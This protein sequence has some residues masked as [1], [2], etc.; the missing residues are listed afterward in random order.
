MWFP[1]EALENSIL[2]GFSLNYRRPPFLGPYL[3]CT[4]SMQHQ[5][6]CDTIAT[7]TSLSS[8]GLHQFQYEDDHSEAES[9]NVL[10]TSRKKLQS[11]EDILQTKCKAYDSDQKKV[12]TLSAPAANVT[13]PN[14]LSF[15][16]LQWLFEIVPRSGFSSCVSFFTHPY[17]LL[18]YL[19]TLSFAAYWPS[20]WAELVFDDRPAIIE[21]KDLHWTSPWSQLW[22]NDYWG[23]PLKSVCTGRNKKANIS[24]NI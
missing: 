10:D 18:T 22:F 9:E 11:G 2:A 1:D 24:L 3:Q 20:L 17:L 7:T 14:L 21:N 13:S 12:A 4:F 16:L 15:P 8:L 5:F 6:V 23:T 19:T